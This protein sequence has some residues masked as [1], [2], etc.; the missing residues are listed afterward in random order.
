MTTLAVIGVGRLVSMNNWWFSGSMLIYQRVVKGVSEE[1]LYIFINQSMG[2]KGHLWTIR[3]FCGLESRS[4]TSKVPENLNPDG[5]PFIQWLRK[6][7]SLPIA[8]YHLDS[9]VLVN[10]LR[11]SLPNRKSKYN[12]D[13]ISESWETY[14][15]E[16]KNGP[17]EDDLYYHL[18]Y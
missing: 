8:A 17:A 1:T 12:L 18:C 10:F 4:T 14:R 7:P 3:S 6:C 15:P 16:K 11:K 5:S 13:T 2:K 9:P